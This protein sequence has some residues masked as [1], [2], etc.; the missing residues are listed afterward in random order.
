MLLQKCGQSNIGCG[1]TLDVVIL[2]F[3]RLCVS[4]LVMLVLTCGGEYILPLVLN[5]IIIISV[6]YDV[7]CIG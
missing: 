1:Q 4:V 3:H 5:T 7:A 6:T 2:H